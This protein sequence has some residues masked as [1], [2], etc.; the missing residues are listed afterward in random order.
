MSDNTE[1]QTPKSIFESSEPP[2]EG[3]QIIDETAGED[4]PAPQV[5]VDKGGN[6]TATMQLEEGENPFDHRAE[7]EALDEAK[8]KVGVN[9]PDLPET[10]D[11]GAQNPVMMA[12]ATDAVR[13]EVERRFHSEFGAVSVEVTPSERED[14]VRAALHDNE[15]KFHVPIEA[16]GINIAVV[17][18]PDAFTTMAAAMAKQWG[19][20]GHIAPDSDM[21]WLLAFQQMHV[22]Y[23]VRE[24]NGEPTSWSSYWQGDRRPMLEIRERMQDPSH[25]DDVIQMPPVRWRMCL[26]A[27]RIAELKYKICLQN[28]HDRT[29]FTSA[30]TA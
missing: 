1:N 26:E 29:F 13:E 16:L 20:D 18:P 11:I 2:E 23:Q 7:Q 19:K 17:T 9:P 10:P 24:V 30:G 15:M 3:A 8:K 12:G 5:E 14:F 27:S 4:T 22:W 25:L 21:E 28:W 6:V